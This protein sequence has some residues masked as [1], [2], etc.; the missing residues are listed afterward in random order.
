MR[1][2]VTRGTAPT[3]PSQSVDDLEAGTIVSYDG[4][5][6]ISNRL[7]IV[8]NILGEKY[9]INLATGYWIG[10]GAVVTPLPKGFSVTVE[11][12]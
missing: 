10:K 8:T 1:N 6:D 2:K 4:A 12:P 7:C 3:P 9:G 5:S 11:T